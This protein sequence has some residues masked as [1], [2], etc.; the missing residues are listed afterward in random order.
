MRPEAS[1]RDVREGLVDAAIMNHLPIDP[2]G[3]NVRPLLI[4]STPV[5]ATPEYLRLH[6]IP[7]TPEDLADHVGLLQESASQTPTQFLYKAGAAS[8]VL[9]WKR[10]FVTHDQM[11]L[12]K[13]ILAHQGITVDLFI[14]HVAEEL[15]RGEICPILPGWERRPW[16]LCLV[17]RTERELES[18]EVRRFAEWWADVEGREATERAARARMA[19]SESFRVQRE[20]AVARFQAQYLG[21][22]KGFAA[23]AKL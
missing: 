23:K 12:K 1:E 2:T 21:F 14:G 11:M 4:N 5:L 19:V 10:V 9:R 6:G 17:T 18:P 16:Q 7:Q 8:P 13:L 20:T 22:P 15:K 3:L